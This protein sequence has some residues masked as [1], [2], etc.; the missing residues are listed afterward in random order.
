MKKIIHVDNSEFFRKQM[1]T[2]LEK[3]GFEVEGFDNAKEADM[4]IGGGAMDMVIMGLTFADSDG[5]AFL[6]RTMASY[7]GPLIVVSSSVN[8]TKSEELITLGAKAVFNKSGPWKDELR[9]HLS[10]LKGA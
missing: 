10:A 5:Q 8:K 3:E 9:P 6:N 1:R 2:F 4:A 7:A